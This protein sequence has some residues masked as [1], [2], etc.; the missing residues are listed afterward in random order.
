MLEES[1]RSGSPHS[2]ADTAESLDASTH[3]VR[4]GTTAACAIMDSCEFLCSSSAHLQLL[5]YEC[6]T[7]CVASSV[8]PDK[9]TDCFW[10]EK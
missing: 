10:R 2:D 7:V 8:T 5:V 9:Y 3:I 6:T 1:F 4:L